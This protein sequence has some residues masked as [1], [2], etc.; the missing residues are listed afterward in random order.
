MYIFVYISKLFCEVVMINLFC[1]SA[2]TVGR[3]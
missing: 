3:I 2:V 1:K